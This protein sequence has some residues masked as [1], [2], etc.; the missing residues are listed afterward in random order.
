MP[1]LT[2]A[3]A[4]C[5]TT[6]APDAPSQGYDGPGWRGDRAAGGVEGNK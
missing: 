3:L 6:P 4:A 1:R 2:L 5:G